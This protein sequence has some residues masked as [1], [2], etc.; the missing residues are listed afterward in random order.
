MIKKLHLILVITFVIFLFNVSTAQIKRGLAQTPPM[1][2]NSWNFFGKQDINEK[3]VYEVIDAMVSTGLRDAGYNYVVIDGGWRDTALAADG[4]LLSHPLK[5]PNGIKPLADYAHSKGLKFGL[6]TVPGTHDCGGNPVGNYSHE[7]LHVKQFVEWGLDFVKLD[8]CRMLGDPCSS[9]PTGRTGWREESTKDLYLKWR[10]EFFYEY[11]WE[12]AF[13]QTPTQF[14][15]RTDRYKFIRAIGVLD[16]DQLYDLQ[17]DP[18]EVNNLIR[19]PEYQTLGKELNAKLWQW[20]D[21]TKGLYIPLKPIL[22]KKKD[23][24]YKG[25]W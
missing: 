3:I 25:T 22:E 23:H 11:Y 1:G 18:Y 24:L 7:E 8:C 4:S 10:K 9:S 5:F 16:T 2:W 17:T 15:V 19:K 13:P 20:L 6:H 12:D 21:D 14:A